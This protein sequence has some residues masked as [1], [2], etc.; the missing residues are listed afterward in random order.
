M[1]VPSAYRE[2]ELLQLIAAGDESAFREFFHLYRDRLYTFIF[3]FTKSAHVTEELVQDIFMK[4]WTNRASLPDIANPNGYLSF[5]ARNK[6]IDYLRKVA[7]ENAMLET[8]WKRIAAEQNTT[9]EQVNM[10]EARRLIEA[11][12]AQLSAQKRSVFH[13]SR[14]EGLSSREIA[15]RLN[16]SE[17]T[18]RNIM[19]EVLK[20]VR[21]YL[22][23]HNVQLALAFAMVFS[24][25]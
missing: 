10:A 1:S 15:E 4:C 11:S 2:S 9:E 22:Q 7:N 12:L 16:L 17:R 19:S 13:L 21:L 20:H 8:V 23:Q 18:V 24:A 5:M 14:Y 6:C 3:R 25:L